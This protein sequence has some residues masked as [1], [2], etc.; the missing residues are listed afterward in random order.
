MNTM[1]AVE[2]VTADPYLLGAIAAL[3]GVIVYLY[4]RIEKFTEREQLRSDRLATIIE[5]AAKLNGNE[6]VA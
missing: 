2:G 4:K 5:N 6:D 1:L 3:S